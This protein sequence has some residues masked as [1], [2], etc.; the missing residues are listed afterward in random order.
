MVRRLSV[1]SHISHPQLFYGTK[2]QYAYYFYKPTSSRTSRKWSRNTHFEC[3]KMYTFKKPCETLT[4]D[5]IAARSKILT[6]R[7]SNCSMMSCQ[8]CLPSSVGNSAKRSDKVSKI[9]NQKYQ[10]DKYTVWAVFFLG[11]A[12]LL[13]AETPRRVGAK[14]AKRLF[15]GFRVRQLHFRWLTTEGGRPRWWY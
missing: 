14:V 1:V 7:S 5:I 6:S 12:H 10:V 4:K 15:D 3:R 9:H 13:L 11:F 8:S 2:S